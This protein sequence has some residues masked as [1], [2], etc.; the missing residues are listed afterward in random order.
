MKKIDALLTKQKNGIPLDP[1]QIACINTLDSVLAQMEKYVS[2]PTA[3][4]VK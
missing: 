3:S 4:S 2:A 1:Q